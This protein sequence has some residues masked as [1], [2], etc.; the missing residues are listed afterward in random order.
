MGKRRPRQDVIDHPE[1]G[2]Y[3]LVRVGRLRYRLIPVGRE[4]AGDVRI[5]LTRYQSG[6]RWPKPVFGQPAPEPIPEFAWHWSIQYGKGHVYSLIHKDG[7]AA[8]DAAL[9]D[10]IEVALRVAD[11]PSPLGFI[12]A[13]RAAQGVELPALLRSIA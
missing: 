7:F 8:S 10:A 2:R 11:A 1:L 5:F 4:F 3:A 13:F 12:N 6:K 9:D